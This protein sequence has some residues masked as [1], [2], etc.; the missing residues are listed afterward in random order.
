MNKKISIIIGI[1]AIGVALGAIVFFGGFSHAQGADTNTVW[2]GGW[3]MGPSLN[4]TILGCPAGNGLGRYTGIYYP[5]QDRVY[6]L[7]GR[8]ENDTTTTGSVFY[9]DPVLG[10]YTAAGVAMPVPVSN[11]QMVQ[12]DDGR[13]NG[14]GFYIIGGRTTSGGQTNAVQVYYPN[15]NTVVQI[16][17]DP[18]PPAPSYSPG[19]VVAVGGKIYVFGGFTGTVMVKSTYIYDPAA[20]VGSRW[21]NANCDLPTARSYIGA[22][23]V[24]TK[25]YAIGGDEYTTSLIPIND[26]VVFD[27]AKPDACWQDNLMAD[28][29]SANGDAPAVYVDEGYMGGGIF[30]VGGNFTSIQ[31]LVYRYDLAGE[32][33]ET[34]PQLVI[35]SPATGRR[36][37]AAVYIPGN[38]VREPRL[39]TFGGFDGSG[40]NA[41]TDS[42][43]FFANILLQP[44]RYEVVGLPGATVADNFTQI[45]PSRVV[46]TYDLSYTSNV[47]WTVGLPANI[48]P[49]PAGSQATFAMTVDIP[50]NADCGDTGSFT[51]ISAAQENAELTAS[52]TITVR[53]ICGV[54]GK[55]SD[56]NS[57]LGI[58]NAY[59]WMQDSVDGLG[60]YYDAYT[61]V[62]GNFMKTDVVPGS[63]YFAAS[64]LHHQ[65][66]FYPTGWPDGAIQ[67]T[68]YPTTTVTLI[69]ATLV[70]SDINWN[71]SALSADMLPN[72]E[73]TQT[74]TISNDGSGP[75]YYDISV[76]DGSQ[77]E[78]PQ[79]GALAVPGLPRVDE[80]IFSD[81]NASAEGTTDFVVVLN[82]QADLSAAYGIRDWN[83]R[84]QAVYDMLN[85]V[86][87]TSQTGLRSFLDGQGVNYTPLYIINAVIVHSGDN[88]LVNSLAARQD[89]SQLVANRK[90]AV[91]KTSAGYWNA[92]LQTVNAPDTVAWG[93]SQIHADDVWGLGFKG[94]GMVVAEIDMGTQY[95]HPA[96][97]NQ[98]RGNHGA[99]VFDHN[100]NWYD[101]YGQC[102]GDGKTP[103]DPNG[104]GTHVMGTM[105]GD[106]GGVNQ[107]G[108]APGAKWISCKGGDQVSNYL[109]TNELLTCAQ[110]ILAPFDL[111]GQNPDPSMRPNVV[112]NSW[113]GGKGD[114]WYTG[115][116]AAWR[117]AGIF[118]A[119]SA[120]NAGPGCTTTGSP[121]DNW[122]SFASGASDKTDTIATFS[123]RG[124]AF[125]TNILKPQITAP[126]VNICS[127]IPGS[128]YNC[129]YSGTSM[130]S[131]HT[132]GSIALLWS[133]APE[134]VGQVDLTAWLL[135]QTAA[136]KTTDEGCGGDTP[137]TVPNNTYG[138]GRLD[139]LAAV[140]LAMNEKLTP[141]WV[142]VTPLYGM[143]NPGES[144]TISVT[145]TSPATAG[146]Y[147]ATLML[148]GDDPYNPDVRIPL[149][150]NVI[151]N[152]AVT[153]VYHDLEDVVHTGEDVYVSGG[154]S[155]WSV[156]GEL[157][158][159]NADYS[160]FTTTLQVAQGT[161]LYKYMVPV[162]PGD[163]SDQQNWELL[164]TND[165][166]VPVSGDMTVNDYRNVVVGLA[167]LDDPLAVTIYLG[168]DSGNLNGEV[169]VRNLTAPPGQGRGIMAQ[170][171]YGV[172]TD[173]AEWTWMDMAYTG[174]NGDNDVFSGVVTPVEAG[175]YH[176][177]VRF[178]GN[179]GVGNPNQGWVDSEQTGVL[180]VLLR[181][182]FLPL[183][184]R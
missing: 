171:G 67:F 32:V 52:A 140:N 157:M 155:G 159:P 34:F 181:T 71:P 165:R 73:I 65:P 24:G 143:I 16:T 97:K 13:G 30:V 3:Q 103:C 115:A 138:Y 76:L 4:T 150:M 40:T 112:N 39:W 139:I 126:G 183:I 37:Q 154:F 153:F 117:A 162:V 25:I 177:G 88:S 164:N 169:F 180:T 36:N 104:H 64:A 167:Q 53:A 15:N 20:S 28:L 61:D 11:Y 114:Y 142:S 18:F 166:S 148:V 116:I 94:E 57:G 82:E 33:W 47:S 19:G 8:C 60:L 44:D 128:A 146:T 9:F 48:G 89:V 102:G 59:V 7:G 6:F 141:D 78:P 144:A 41:M 107:I 55:I 84:G 101:P 170:L 72:S 160:V 163:L 83:T 5:A 77:A 70:A 122:H 118:P 158:T 90:I 46:Y 184:N 38:E 137:T 125:N 21:T 87:E 14:P 91:E 134:L 69:N 108:V 147:T 133:S 100:Y 35:P 127:S 96:L 152:K 81:I 161:Y 136:P 145:F 66:S 179:W 120:G 124:P 99:G 12:I 173:P 129:T 149:T 110:W 176:Y 43:E 106:D 182:I 51:V 31:R 119:F 174:D 105:V 86:A 75:Y 151:E 123:S 175:I 109:L 93:V 168:Q 17:T 130:A 10:T 79:A 131:P 121:G 172:S 22:V 92:P 132:A 74:L 29:P 135:E 111:N 1:F 49:I 68:T 23:A 98:Y 58:P 62:N 27:T 63:Y 42:S 26:T 54:V 45:N 50:S 156:P 85:Q 95:D 56:A 178:D 2:K 80:Q 113:G